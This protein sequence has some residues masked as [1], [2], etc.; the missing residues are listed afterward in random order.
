MNKTAKCA[1][2]MGH[3][4]PFEIREYP[5]LP[6]PPGYGASTL[7]ASGICGTDLHIHAG[8]LGG[9]AET[10]LGH[11]FVGRLFDCDPTE[12]AAYGL[13][14][15]D[16]VI[17]DIAV[18][19][20]ECPLC[21][22]GDDANCIRMQCTNEE[23][24]THAPHFFG[25]YGEVNYTP[26]ANLVKIPAE[27]DPRMVCTFACPG[28]TAL[29]AFSIAKRANIDL[30]SM[31]TA[32]VQGLGP[33]GMFA[34]LYL[35]AIG[36]ENVYAVSTGKNP[37]RET[38]ALG[39]G[40]KKVF[41]LN[42]DHAVENMTEELLAVTNGLGV[43]LVY[44]ASGAPA[45][46]PVG[47]G[48]LRNRGV[49]LIPGQYSDQGTVAISPELITFKA[50]QILGSS[51]YSMVDVRDYLTFLVEHPALHERILALGKGY[52]VEKV[53]EA[54]ADAYAGKNIKSMLVK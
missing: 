15:G 27:L 39:F 50:L 43:D 17:A 42:E 11:E 5:I 7:L 23:M 24:V 35:C 21:L 44:E 32:V 33:V 8:R 1:V 6:P 10:M 18:P 46:I 16:A 45:A 9:E 4:V 52:P 53:N 20:G 48:L 31:H 37:A 34:A 54:F 36:V 28:P 40:V 30:A 3:D 49:Y 29:H 25:G 14:V 51:Q 12:A 13:A 38:A 22:S 19:C 47:M 2:F 41:H 26:L